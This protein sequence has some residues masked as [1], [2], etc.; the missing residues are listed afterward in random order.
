MH[1]QPKNVRFSEC[2][3]PMGVALSMLDN[4][5]HWSTRLLNSWKFWNEVAWW[6][7]PRNS[8]FQGLSYQSWDIPHHPTVVNACSPLKFSW[9][10]FPLVFWRVSVVL[11]ALYIE[12]IHWKILWGARRENRSTV[13]HWKR[14]QKLP[15]SNKHASGMVRLMEEILITSWGL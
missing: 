10:H 1:V 6:G 11:D 9:H 12:E 2:K 15:Q 5:G 13:W 3:T 4:F 14:R 7:L 8:N